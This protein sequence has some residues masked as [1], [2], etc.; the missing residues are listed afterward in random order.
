MTLGATSMRRYGAAPRRRP[1]QTKPSGGSPAQDML[2]RANGTHSEMP[3]KGAIGPVNG[4]SA[5]RPA[6]VFAADLHVI[7]L[8]ECEGHLEING[9]V[10]GEINCQ[11]VSIGPD[12]LVTGPIMAQNAVIGGTVDG[13]ISAYSVTLTAT[14]HVEGSIFHHHLQINPGAVHRGRKPWRLNPLDGS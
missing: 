5:Q 1:N 6:S 3:A 10:E 7:G 4:I 14:A 11:S 12:A 13:Q 2:A 9:T 8:I